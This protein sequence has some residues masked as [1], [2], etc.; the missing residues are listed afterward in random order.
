MHPGRPQ[1]SHDDVHQRA[2]EGLPLLMRELALGFGG[3]RPGAAVID[4]VEH[5]ALPS[6]VFHVLG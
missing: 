4:L 3:G 2:A 1:P 6:K 5:R